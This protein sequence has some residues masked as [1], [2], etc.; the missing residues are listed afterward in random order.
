MMPKPTQYPIQ[1]AFEHP[2]HFIHRLQPDR[3]PLLFQHQF[4]IQHL[5]IA[6]KAQQPLVMLR[7]AFHPQ[8]FLLSTHPPA[9]FSEE[10]FF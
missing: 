8:I 9:K 10:P 2:R 1:M 3:H 7:K 6:I 4:H 5:P